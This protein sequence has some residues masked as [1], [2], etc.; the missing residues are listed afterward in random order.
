MSNFSDLVQQGSA[1]AWLFIPTAVLIGALHGLEPGHSKTMMA[2]FIIAV[3]G[4]IA[5]AVLLG[6]AAAVS[7]SL[8]IWG[9][10]GL[11][12]YYGQ[13]WDMEKNEPYFQLVSAVIIAGMAVWMFRRTRRELNEA[14][15]HAHTH[16][17]KEKGSIDTG[18]GWVAVSEPNQFNLK[19]PL[20]HHD[21]GHEPGVH[22]HEQHHHDELPEDVIGYQDA[23]ELA[24]ASD[25]ERRFANQHVTTWQIIIFGLTGGL[26]P[27]P[28]AI[29]VLLLC[30]QLKKFTLG[31]AL[32][33]AFSFGLALTLVASGTIAAWSVQHAQRRFR[34]FGELMRKAPYVSV[35]VLLS[36]SAYIAWHAWRTLNGHG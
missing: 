19:P 31:F 14:R 23:H 18:Q 25:I 24:H 1:H 29:T 36:I 15:D 4:T 10:A 26:L 20:K 3:R 16:T 21:H 35:A 8:I 9:V 13:N 33:L 6:L 22:V 17:H 32:V 12:L 30:L 27:C 28:A 11:G 34:G 7:H 2:A 5:Q